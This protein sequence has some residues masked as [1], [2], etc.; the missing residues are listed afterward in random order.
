MATGRHTSKEPNF[1]EI[2]EDV[3]WT[4][5]L[6]TNR[7]GRESATRARV[8][9]F[10][11]TNTHEGKTE[12]ITR[13]HVRTVGGLTIGGLKDTREEAMELLNQQAIID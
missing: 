8:E 5:I 12:V 6:Y 4:P 10:L 7:Q 1:T 11:L 3:I 2:E 13:W 9:K